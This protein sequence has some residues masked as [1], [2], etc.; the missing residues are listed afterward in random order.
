[1]KKIFPIYL[2]WNIDSESFPWKE[3]RASTVL[4]DRLH[5]SGSMNMEQSDVQ[6]FEMF[7]VCRPLHPVLPAVDSSTMGEKNKVTYWTFAVQCICDAAHRNIWVI[8]CSR[9]H[10]F[11]QRSVTHTSMCFSTFLLNLRVMQVGRLL[12]T[13]FLCL[14]A[15]LYPTNTSNIEGAWCEP[16]CLFSPRP[17]LPIRLHLHPEHP[18]LWIDLVF[19][20]FPPTLFLQ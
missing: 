10:S 7:S 18:H 3:S 1:M 12:S 4:Y 16:D 2:L 11:T 8:L 5:Q 14:T 15:S 20:F 13:P 17:A 19:F 9:L 6:A